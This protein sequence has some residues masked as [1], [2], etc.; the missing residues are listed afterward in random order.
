MRVSKLSPFRTGTRRWTRSHMIDAAERHGL[1]EHFEV[2]VDHLHD[3]R[4]PRAPIVS[5]DVAGV[6]EQLAGLKLTPTVSFG[7]P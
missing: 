7:S 5:G 4:G 6:R 1:V 2:A 3:V